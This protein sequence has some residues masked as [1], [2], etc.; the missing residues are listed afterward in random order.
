M[1]V[2]IA[3]YAS[4]GANVL[5]FFLNVFNAVTSSSYSGAYDVQVS[6]RV[7]VHLPCVCSAGGGAGLVPGHLLGIHSVADVMGGGTHHA[8]A[9]PRRQVALRAA[10]RH[11]LLG[12]HVHRHLPAAHRGRQGPLSLSLCCCFLKCN[13]D[14]LLLFLYI[15]IICNIY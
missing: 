7:L 8:P 2:K 6:M 12:V 9:V 14:S 5:L 4:L 13:T 10:G 1:R 11:H 15:R 3:I